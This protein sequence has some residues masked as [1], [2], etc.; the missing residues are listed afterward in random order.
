MQTAADSCQ[1]KFITSKCQFTGDL[2]NADSCQSKFITVTGKV[3]QCDKLRLTAVCISEVT[4][5]VTQCDKLKN[6][7]CLH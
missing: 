4:G 5:K 1:S 3:T 7:S 6:D 2:T